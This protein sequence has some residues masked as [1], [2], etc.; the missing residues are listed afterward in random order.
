[1]SNFLNFAG[2]Q[3]MTFKTFTA[4]GTSYTLDKSASTNSVLVSVGGVMQQP[5]VDYTVSGTT[6][7]STS[8]WTAGVQVDTFI[9]HKPGTAPTIQDN[10]ITSAKIA[11]DQVDSQ[12]LAAGSVD[13]EHMSSQSVDEDNLHISNAGS[14]G[15]FLSKQSGDA[16]GLTWTA[17]STGFT[18]G[19]EAAAT[20]TS[21]GFT[22]IP[23]GTKQIIITFE[24]IVQS[25][26]GNNVIVEIGDAGGLETSGYVSSGTRV[27]DSNMTTSTSYYAIHGQST[28]AMS[29]HFTLTLSDS[30]NNTWIASHLFKVGSNLHL[31]GGSKSLSAVL[32]QV[33]L[34]PGGSQTFSSGSFNVQ[35]IS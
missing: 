35:Y 14:N 4:S 25:G 29:G 20:G 22:G 12:H 26:T 3:G 21:V 23:S 1:M 33:R 13:L 32:T 10:S 24:E 2:N 9:I 30:T 17:L 31:G 7:T 11:N 34:D 19:T 27:S 16:G 18:L 5:G 8:A 28:D 6:L 15:Q